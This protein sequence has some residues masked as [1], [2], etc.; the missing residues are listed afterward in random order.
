VYSNVT[1][2]DQL[3][4]LQKPKWI[5]NLLT[6]MHNHRIS[7]TNTVTIDMS[8]PLKFVESGRYKVYK[9]QLK[10]YPNMSFAAKLVP[11]DTL[12]EESEEYLEFYR[13]VNCLR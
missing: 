12:I 5:K 4:A 7:N 13:D 6:I 9:V 11:D 1:D 8:N 3:K 10:E 2:I